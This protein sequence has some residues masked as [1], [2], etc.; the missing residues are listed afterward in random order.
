M[1][2]SLRHQSK[3]QLEYLDTQ[4]KEKPKLIDAL[5]TNLTCMLTE[6]G[7]GSGIFLLV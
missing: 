7:G 1:V 6:L 4:R 3:I 5:R 2:C